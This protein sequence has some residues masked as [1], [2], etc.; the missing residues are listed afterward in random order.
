MWFDLFIEFIT[1]I[2]LVKSHGIHM[3][4]SLLTTNRKCQRI[5]LKL[6]LGTTI[7]DKTDKQNR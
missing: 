6:K 7:R 5:M 1:D 2:M 3:R 4:H